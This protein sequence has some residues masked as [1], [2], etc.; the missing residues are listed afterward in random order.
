MTVCLGLSL[1]THPS[2]DGVTV[3]LYSV[4]HCSVLR[5]Q[6]LLVPLQLCVRPLASAAVTAYTT[7]ATLLFHLTD[8]TP[9]PQFTTGRKV[10]RGQ[11]AEQKRKRSWKSRSCYTRKD[12]L[13]VKDN[14]LRYHVELYVPV[15][16]CFMGLQELLQTLSWART[17]T[18]YVCPHCMFCTTQYCLSVMQT[19]L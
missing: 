1:P 18:L 4:P 16:T 7:P 5:L 11:G 13:F 15:S 10:E 3:T 9:V 14:T 17:V 2:L 8:T 12:A 19:L 6:P